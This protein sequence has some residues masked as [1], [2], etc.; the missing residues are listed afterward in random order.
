MIATRS[1][2]QILEV[3]LLSYHSEKNPREHGQM[4]I[5]RHS[6][7]SDF[8]GKRRKYGHVLRIWKEELQIFSAVETEW[9][10][11]WDSDFSTY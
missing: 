9:R 10:R 1:P 6:L 2:H 8:F 11:G 4:G 5:K 7:Q 3:G